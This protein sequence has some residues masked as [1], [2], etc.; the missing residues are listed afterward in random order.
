VFALLGRIDPQPDAVRVPGALHQG[1]EPHQP[2]H[3]IAGAV[4]SPRLVYTAGVLATFRGSGRCIAGAASRRRRR[5]A[6]ASSC[7][8]PLPWPCSP[9]CCSP[10]AQPVRRGHFGYSLQGLGGS[11][12]QRAGYSGSFFAGALAVVVATPCTAPF[13]GTALGFALTQPPPSASSCSWR[14]ASASPSPSCC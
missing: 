7:S 5:S 12:A 8:R 9:T 13:M 1:A 11:L 14:S 6:G 2:R 4:A 3:A 10:W